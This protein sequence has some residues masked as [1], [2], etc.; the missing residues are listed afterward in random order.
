MPSL[1]TLL[2]NPTWQVLRDHCPLLRSN[3]LY[4]LHQYDI[5]IGSPRCFIVNI[6][7]HVILVLMIVIILIVNM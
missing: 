6:V 5:L 7:V 3:L 4:E 1:T 2:A